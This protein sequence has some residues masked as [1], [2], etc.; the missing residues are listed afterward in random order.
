MKSQW[1]ASVIASMAMCAVA[2]GQANSNPSNTYDEP[3]PPPAAQGGA[4]QDNQ[5]PQGP[6]QLPPQGDMRGN[7]SEQS[8]SNSTPQRERF[9]G[10]SPENQ[11]RYR[12]WNGEWW[13][14]MPGNYWMFYRGNQWNR[15]DESTF[16]RPAQIVQSPSTYYYN[17]DGRGYY[18]RGYDGYGYGYGPGYGYG[19]YG[20]GYRGYGPYGGGYGY[21]PYFSGNSNVRNGAIIGGAIGGREGAYIGGAIGGSTGGRGRG[22]RR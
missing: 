22:A 16:Q 20:T 8:M 19:R 18:G 17:D 11:W 2:Y 15:Y 21:N 10:N 6:P 14:W 9:D 13:Y 1:I 3:P 7:Q 5:G 4:N 12:N